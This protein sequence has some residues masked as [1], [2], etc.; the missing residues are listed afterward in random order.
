MRVALAILLFAALA[1]ADNFKLYLK[2]GTNHLVR[3]YKVVEDRVVYYS[4]ERSDFEELPLDLVDLKKTES[5]RKVRGEEEKKNAAF[6]DAEEKFEREVAREIARVPQDSGVY[7]VHE[8]K[9]NAL[10][11]AE[12][13][14]ITDKR[15][16]IL[17]V[18]SPIPI[19][20]GKAVLELAGDNAEIAVPY[21]RPNFYFRIDSVQ[22]FSIVRMKPRKSGRQ[23]AIWNVEP[24]TKLV[25]FDMELVDVFR[26]QLRD[27]LY[28]LWPTQ[29][30][31][32]GE[33]AVVQYV[34]GDGQIQVWDFRVPLNPAKTQ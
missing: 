8:G 30:L 10:K 7:F 6:D 26:Q 20:A 12:V 23:V 9:M 22:R 13:K 2:D 1:F 27:N 31:S 16:T 14:S 4:I 19:V 11:V 3:E 5:E 24:V 29:P 21:E 34:E 25:A 33:Y 15:R 18:M 28:K 17:K 32:P